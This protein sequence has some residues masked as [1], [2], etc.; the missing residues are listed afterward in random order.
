MG[1]MVSNLVDVTAFILFSISELVFLYIGTTQEEKISA[2]LKFFCLFT[3]WNL[4]YY[5]DLPRLYLHVLV[6]SLGGI[7]W[8]FILRWI[9]VNK[10]LA[11]PKTGQAAVFFWVLF[12]NAI[13]ILSILAVY[14]WA[15]FSTHA[16]ANEKAWIWGSKMLWLRPVLWVICGLILLIWSFQW[17]KRTARILYS[18]LVLGGLA[19]TA[20]LVYSASVPVFRQ[21]SLDVV[22]KQISTG[23]VQ[24]ITVTNNTIKAQTSLGGLKTT[25]ENGISALE[26]FRNLGVSDQDLKKISIEI[27]PPGFGDPVINNVLTAIGYILPFLILSFVFYFLFKQAKNP[28]QQFVNSQ[29]NLEP[30]EEKSYVTFKDVGGAKEAKEALIDIVQFLKEPSPFI[31]LGATMPKGILLEGPPGTGKT[32][33]ARAV[34]GEAGVPFFYISGSEFIEMF[35][36]VGASRI[37]KLFSAAKSKAPCVVFIDELDAIG[38]RREGSQ[39]LHSENN[40]SLNQLLTELDGFH[41]DTSIVVMGATNRYDILDEALVRPGRFDQRV[42]VSLPDADERKTILR[43]HLKGIPCD[44]KDADLDK[45]ADSGT[46]LSG[47]DLAAIANRSAILASKD[48]SQ[49]IQR[50]HLET[51][52]KKVGAVLP[53]LNPPGLLARTLNEQVIGQEE[54][55]KALAVAIFQHYSDI[56]QMAAHPNQVGK[57]PNVLLFGPSGT[58]K[59]R[60]IQTLTQQLEIPHES[61]DAVSLL[62]GHSRL[63]EVLG[64]LVVAARQD[65]RRAKYGVIC[66][67]GIEDLLLPA[68]IHVQEELGRIIEGMVFDISYRDNSLINRSIS[69]DTSH[70][71]FIC[72]GTFEPAFKPG[73]RRNPTPV[74][75][76]IQVTNEDLVETGFQPRLLD[77]FAFIVQTKTLHKEQMLNILS[78][79][80]LSLVRQY[81]HRF[82]ALGT[83]LAFDSAALNEIVQEAIYRGGNARWMDQILQE[84]LKEEFLAVPPKRELSITAPLVWK[85]LGSEAIPA[86]VTRPNETLANPVHSETEDTDILSHPHSEAKATAAVPYPQLIEITHPVRSDQAEAVTPAEA[87]ENDD[88]LLSPPSSQP[89]VAVDQTSFA[90]SE[91]SQSPFL[92]ITLA[93]KEGN[94][95]AV[96]ANRQPSHQFDL[97]CIT[98]GPQPLDDPAAYGKI[99]FQALFPNGS[100]LNK[101]IYSGAKSILLVAVHPALQEIAWEYAYGPDGWLVL[102]HSLVRGL[103]AE[104]RIAPPRISGGLNVI[105]VPADPLEN[106][107]PAL[108]IEGEWQR[109]KEIFQSVPYTVQLE[110]ANPP[111]LGNLRSLVAHQRNRIVH[112]MGHGTQSQEGAVLCFENEVGGLDEVTARDFAQRLKGTVFMVTLNACVTAAAGP[113]QFSNLAYALVNQ[114]TPYA[115]GMHFA[116]ADKDALDLSRVLYSEIAR[117]SPVEEAVQQVRQ[118][119]AKSQNAWAVGIPVLYTALKS[120]TPGFSFTPGNPQ[121][122]EHRVRL[123]LSAL[124]RVEGK[125]QA[126]FDELKELGRYLTGEQRPPVITIHGA[127]GQGKTTLARAAVERFA[128]AWPGG[129]FAVSLENLP[130]LETFCR[131]LAHFLEVANDDKAR[132]EDIKRMLLDRLSQKRTLIVLDNADTLLEAVEQKDPSALD[133]AQF[134]SQNLAGYNTSLLITS[135]TIMGWGEVV[136]ELAGLNPDAGGLLFLQSASHSAGGSS[137]PATRQYREERLAAELSEKLDGHPLALFLLGK[138]FQAQNKPLAEFVQDFEN[139]LHEA[140]YKYRPETDR[141]CTLEN[142]IDVSLAGLADDNLRSLLFKLAI[143]H[144]PFLPEVVAGIMSDENLHNQYEFIGTLMD[145]GTPVEVMG[146]LS[147]ED[148]P[149][150]NKMNTDWIL[151]NQGTVFDQLD[152]LWKRGLLVREVQMTEEPDGQSKVLLYRV[153]PTIQAYLEARAGEQNPYQEPFLTQLG[154]AYCELAGVLSN[155][156][157]RSPTKVVLAQKMLPD[158]MGALVFTQGQSRVSYLVSLGPILQR[159]GERELLEK[160]TN[161]ARQ[162]IESQGPVIVKTDRHDREQRRRLED[163]MAA[164]TQTGLNELNTGQIDQ[165]IKTWEELLSLSRASGDL[166][167]ESNTLSNIGSAYRIQGRNEEALKYFQ[168][169]QVIQQK[170]KDLGGEAKSLDDMGLVYL[171]C[172]G[173]NPK[174]L[175]YFQ[176]ARHLL[177]RQDKDGM[178]GIDRERLGIILNNIG[179]TY[180]RM[181]KSKQA[182]EALQQALTIQQELQSA[183]MGATLFN[184]ARIAREQAN[185]QQADQLLEEALAYG[186]RASRQDIVAAVYMELGVRSP[187][188]IREQWYRKAIQT[189]RTMGEVASEI[190]A[191]GNLANVL[192]ELG[193]TDEAIQLLEDSIQLLE[194]HH[195]T[196]DTAGASIKQYRNVLSQL[197][198]NPKG[199]KGRS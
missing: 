70:I 43:I 133:L 80:D 172:Y 145:I 119:M 89:E 166:T 37:R 141:H 30:Q 54:A 25:K 164:I 94:Q 59:T 75:G 137:R 121:I 199:K 178:N 150:T 173:D 198:Q 61:L 58:G 152:L 193:K 39:Q 21:V 138:A 88:L 114:G 115:L 63:R 1:Y 176:R 103:P 155:D 29:A 107:I 149:I 146:G 186:Q 44:I 190:A 165:A 195:L 56:R 28:G 182:M 196:R 49:R 38:Q 120:S 14:N 160:V 142:C 4:A 84:I 161:E 153:L 187:A 7:A 48:H 18:A 118:Q 108:N 85:A 192:S 163:Q 113:T 31:R 158:L 16:A 117:G 116:L 167:H 19:V 2:R 22:A 23:Q 97:N 131:N 132:I 52:F 191:M 148:M 174:A 189:Y 36:G 184:L 157:F 139:H 188:K 130:S 87:P 68:F 8:Y 12:V 183:Q 78:D 53:E 74:P 24:K 66:I 125:F 60:L 112:F 55:A 126:R 101:E 169:A 9:R 134:I 35:V 123:D 27:R 83:L 41:Q 140:Q 13:V 129:V 177:E 32:L 57:K 102:D 3:G 105:A 99:V 71:L 194:A 154:A 162:L 86:A 42:Y 91:H 17:F 136:L 51:A 81:Q 98:T 6:A 156:I 45:M 170:N 64:R 15:P 171:N 82:A 111:T 104:H 10:I 33:L 77:K 122:E 72:E 40:Q 128:H 100:V 5:L 73:K 26:T 135:R 76:P 180:R 197:R 96:F 179:E 143:F 34:A 67:Y 50:I 106:G 62:E 93:I 147:A 159:F 144:A 11:S 69:I 92:E 185:P 109:I 90:K 168:Q 124:R 20:Y 47:A 79:G 151:F 181:G 110:K 46:D 175:S 65:L 127:G 95:V